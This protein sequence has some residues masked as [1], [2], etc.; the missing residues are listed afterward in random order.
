MI[1]TSK[2]YDAFMIMGLFLLFIFCMAFQD[3]HF[4]TDIMQ[5]YKIGEFIMSNHS[6]PSGDIY[7][8]QS[9]LSAM[10]HEQLYDSYLYI[11]LSKLGTFGCKLSIVIPHMILM[12]LFWYEN[13]NNIKNNQLFVAYTFTVYAYCKSSNCGR[14]MEY[15]ILIFLLV[16]HVLNRWPACKKKYILLAI[17]SVFISNFHGG[18]LV[19]LLI[20]CVIFLI[21]DL[22]TMF[23]KKNY[24]K[25]VLLENIKCFA[26]I[27]ISSFINPYGPYIQ[28]YFISSFIPNNANEHIQEW[29]QPDIAVIYAVIIIGVSLCIGCCEEFKTINQYAQRNI[30]LLCAF[31]CQSVTVMRMMYYACILLIFIAYPYVEKVVLNFI[32]LPEFNSE[33]SL[34]KVKISARMFLLASVA[35]IALQFN[36]FITNNKPYIEAARENSKDLAEITDYIKENDLNGSHIFN[37]YND[38]G[39]LILND[40]KTFIDPRCDP[41]MDWFSKGNTTLQDYMDLYYKDKYN[42]KKKQKD[43]IK[44]YDI[45]YVILQ[46]SSLVDT[47]EKEALSNAGAKEL[48][49]N[50]KYQLYSTDTTKHINNNVG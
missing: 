5:H 16:I 7:S 48:C 24:E 10:Y 27:S 26:I 30:M 37:F 40:V 15:S 34:K 18:A 23:I 21:S 46:K 47:V 13:R 11:L 44:K 3:V 8:W 31:V 49:S 43:F 29:S 36:F 28:K 20:P 25:D 35:I 50:D 12:F 32:K 22:L 39:F 6:L 42:T 38:G 14:P 45:Q 41:Y 33:T 17:C 4:D 9:G 1:K 19:S 2:K